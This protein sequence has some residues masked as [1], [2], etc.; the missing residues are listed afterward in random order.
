MLHE[1]HIH[2]GAWIWRCIPWRCHMHGLGCEALVC[3]KDMMFLLC[4][5]CKEVPCSTCIV[6]TVCSNMVACNTCV[7]SN[8]V[9]FLCRTNQH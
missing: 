9:Q 1:R 8:E 3:W 2:K 6:G 7:Y 5:Y 4:M